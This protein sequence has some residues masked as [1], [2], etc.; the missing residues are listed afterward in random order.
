MHAE[1]G[2]LFSLSSLFHRRRFSLEKKPF[3]SLLHLPVARS[4]RPRQKRV[5]GLVLGR[6]VGVTDGRGEDVTCVKW[7]ERER[8]LS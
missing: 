7:R 2:L 4:P 3:N 8:E 6:S 1:K 5:Q